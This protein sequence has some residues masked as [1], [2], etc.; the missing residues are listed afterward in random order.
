MSLPRLATGLALYKST[1]CHSGVSAVGFVEE[2]GVSNSRDDVMTLLSK[3]M[4]R[5]TELLRENNRNS[6]TFLRST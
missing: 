6:G 3:N 2:I 4:D 5:R 1:S